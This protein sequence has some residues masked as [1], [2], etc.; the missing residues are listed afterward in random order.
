[1]A[2]TFQDFQKEVAASGLGNAFSTADMA[3]ARDYPDVGK[4]IL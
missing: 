4:Q 2:Y 3:L 1:M